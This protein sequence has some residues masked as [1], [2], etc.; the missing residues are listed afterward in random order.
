MEMVVDFPE[1]LR[2]D[3]HFGNQ[4]VK[5]D[6]PVR[7]GGGDSAPEYMSW[8]FVNNAV[9]QPKIFELS[10]GCKAIQ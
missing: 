5:T 8:D 2:V 1:G 9:Y 3:T 7:A 10:N 4:T 6:Q